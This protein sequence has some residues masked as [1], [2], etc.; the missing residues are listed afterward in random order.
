MGVAIS[1]IVTW[2]IGIVLVLVFLAFIYAQ[3]TLDQGLM[4]L[5][6]DSFSGLD[7]RNE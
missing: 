4:G 6:R 7:P 1:K 5:V 2:V 3:L